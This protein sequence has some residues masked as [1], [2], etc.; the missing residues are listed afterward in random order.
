MSD[1]NEDYYDPFSQ[2]FLT[3]LSDVFPKLYRYSQC[4]KCKNISWKNFLYILEESWSHDEA[5]MASSAYHTYCHC[6]NCKHIWY[7]IHSRTVRIKREYDS[8]GQECNIEE[9]DEKQEIQYYP[10]LPDDKDQNNYISLERIAELKQISSATFDLQRLVKLCEEINSNF[11]NGNY[12]AVIALT[13]AVIDHIPPL[14]GVKKFQEVINNYKS[15]RPD[16]KSSFQEIMEYLDKSAKKFADYYL[17]TQ[18][19]KTELLPTEN[20][21]NFSNN[22]DMLFAE[23]VRILKD[24]N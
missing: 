20:Q 21:I 5:E 7:G 14:F 2:S 15:T 4:P 18:I 12:L 16:K 23:I 10:P 13:R 3:V 17:H 11:G 19:R 22:L 1:S 9:V 24:K 8:D 6:T